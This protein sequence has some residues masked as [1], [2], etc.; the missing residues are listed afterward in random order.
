MHVD[1]NNQG[2]SYITGV[3]NYHY[4]E[5]FFYDDSEDVY[6][7][8]TMTNAIPRFGTSGTIL[9]GNIK[10]IKDTVITFNGKLPHGTMPFQGERFALICFFC[11]YDH[12]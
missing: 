6:D 3:G 9:R 7:F 1:R 10:T 5:T 8:Y 4:G 2:N 11:E 12:V